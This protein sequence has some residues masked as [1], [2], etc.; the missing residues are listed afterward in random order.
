MSADR[1][2]LDNLQQD[3][4]GRLGLR[5][6]R[7]LAEQAE[8]LPHV[9]AE[10]LRAAREQALARARLARRRAAA[11]QPAAAAVAAGPALA[12]GGGAPSVWRRFVAL[13]P[14]LLLLA[15]LLVIEHVAMREQVIAAAEFDALLLADDLPPT[16]YSD[17]GFAEFR[18]LAP[19]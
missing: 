6:G 13:A 12:L 17:P 5:L 2:P 18:R 3:A 14:L 10:R 4:A 7:M 8:M 19:P 15:G 16:A 9:P 11:P 1:R